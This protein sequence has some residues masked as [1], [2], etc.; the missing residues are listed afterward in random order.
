MARKDRLFSL[1]SLLLLGF[2]GFFMTPSL[3]RSQGSLATVTPTDTASDIPTL[4]PNIIKTRVTFQSDGLTLVGYLF[5][6]Q[7][8][9]P[10]PGIIWNHGSEKSPGTG[11]EFDAVADIF[12]PV[13]YVVF[14]PVRRG[15]GDSQ[16]DYIDDVVTADRQK[17]GAD[18]AAQ[19][20]VQLFSGQQLDDQLAGFAYLKALPYVDSNRLAVVGCSYG[21]IETLLAAEKNPGFKAAVAESPGAES[22]G[23]KYLQA[24]LLKAVDNIN[25]PVFLL[26]PEMDASVGPG[27]TLGQEF[28]RL[29]KPYGLEI[30][31]PF[32]PAN[33]QGHCFGGAVG[34]HIWAPD[35]LWFLSNTVK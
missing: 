23:N 33:E 25:I 13:G 14:A 9:G 32:G 34:F 4:A 8:G 15:H 5:R 7:G 29:G 2:A 35:V 27:Y 31:P 6:P 10:F 21:G 22:W 20:L 30:Y 18:S 28:Q 16:G 12:V 19:L 3:V 11:P 24:R 17:N 26:H 1:I